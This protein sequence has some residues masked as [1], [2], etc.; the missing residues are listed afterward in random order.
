VQSDEKEAEPLPLFSGMRDWAARDRFDYRDP[1]R[2]YFGSYRSILDDTPDP[3]DMAHYLEQ[4]MEAAQ[5]ALIKRD[6]DALLTAAEADVIDKLVAEYLVSC[7]VVYRDR[8]ALLEVKEMD[9]RGAMQS[10]H[11]QRVVVSVPFDGEKG[12]FWLSP[13]VC[14]PDPPHGDV[15]DGKLKLVWEGVGS[16]AQAVQRY[17]ESELDKIEEYLARA[18][19]DLETYHGQLRT[20]IP[21]WVSQRREELLSSRNLEAGLEFL[22]HKRADAVK[23]S[24]PVRRRTII[25]QRPSADFPFTP[26]PVL[27]EADYE[28]A[29]AVLRNTRNALERSPKTAAKLGEETIR[30]LLLVSL[31]AQ[32]EGKAAGEV[33]NGAGRTDI[34]I[35]DE[36][37][38]VFIAECKIW[39]GPKTIRDALNQLLD[40][41]VW[42]DTK[43]ALLIFIRRSNTTTILDKA[44]SEIKSH[45]NC[46]RTGRS[47][48]EGERYDFV[49]HANGDPSREIRLAFLPFALGSPTE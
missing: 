16:D 14:P 1:W 9:G 8:I 25:P 27:A 4:R 37:R 31:N 6:P 15:R 21:Q 32:F 34:L 44:V 42:R 26:E 36:D 24:V 13:S 46:K 3:K 38:N 10:A 35:R 29:L 18:R 39:R 45:P 20:I 7:P 12:V 30:D 43:A 40:Y 2:D 5:Q 23:Y 48:G 11:Q 47:T 22:I 19:N 33:F 28:S 17:F 41:L 49:F